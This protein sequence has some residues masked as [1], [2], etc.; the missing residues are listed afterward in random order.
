KNVFPASVA[1]VL[2][3][4]RD[5]LIADCRVEEIVSKE[6]G[7]ETVVTFVF[8]QVCYLFLWRLPDLKCFYPGAHTTKWPML[9]KLKVSGCD[10]MKILGT[11]RLSISDTAK[12][13]GQL[14]STLIQP[15]LLLAEKVI[16]KLEKLSLNSDDIA[17]ISESQF[18]RSLFR[19]IKILRVSNSGDESVVFPITFL[20][21][22]DNLEKLVVIYY[23]FKEL[24]CNE[25]DS[26]METY[27]GTLPT[28]RSLKLIRLHNLKHLW[29]QDVQVD[30]ILP[31]LE[32]L[33]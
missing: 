10:K 16:P 25:R 7:L 29:K 31:N 19:E 11:E 24:F 22:F 33:K 14:E 20:E 9:K 18:S 28:I 27:A 12:V 23:E 4:L 2:P 15:P 3:Q 26:G 5:L 1:K 21:R 8:D 6:E 30:R 13:D 17:M 32:T